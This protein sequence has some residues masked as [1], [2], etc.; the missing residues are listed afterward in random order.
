MRLAGAHLLGRQVDVA[1][2]E[3]RAG[4]DRRQSAGLSQKRSAVV[5]ARTWSRHD[6]LSLQRKGRE[7]I[8]DVTYTP[9]RATGQSKDAGVL[10]HLRMCLAARCAP[11]LVD[12]VRMRRPVRVLDGRATV[13]VLQSE[14]DVTSLEQRAEHGQIA[15][16]RSEH[17]RGDS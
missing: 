7:G 2:A 6:G 13:P 16:G 15:D 9:G 5:D 1:D 4:G 12:G 3:W 10:F 8:E 11:Q 17:Q 14:I